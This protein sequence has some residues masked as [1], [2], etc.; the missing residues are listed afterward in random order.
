MMKV[1][2]S[3]LCDDWSETLLFSPPKCTLPLF[4]VLTTSNNE[5]KTLSVYLIRAISFLKLT[6]LGKGNQA[7]ELLKTQNSSSFVLLYLITWMIWCTWAHI[8]SICHGSTLHHMRFSRTGIKWMEVE[9]YSL[10]PGKRMKCKQLIVSKS[11]FPVHSLQRSS[12]KLRF[13]SWFYPCL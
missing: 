3:L 4:G 1:E 6:C 8:G 9:M 7:L 13:T 11:A 10:C 2:V 12:F 5:Q